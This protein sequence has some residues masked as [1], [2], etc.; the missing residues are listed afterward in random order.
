MLVRAGSYPKMKK[1]LQGGWGGGRS[2]SPPMHSLQG[3][4][5]RCRLGGPLL[6]LLLLLWSSSSSS[7]LLSS[8]SLFS[9]VVCQVLVVVDVAAGGCGGGACACWYVL[10]AT[11]K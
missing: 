6:L 3:L 1:E 5:C 10:G 7:L 2:A 8:L 9:V 4:H 11:L